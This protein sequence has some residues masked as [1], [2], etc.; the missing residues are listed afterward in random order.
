MNKD[1]SELRTQQEHLI[2]DISTLINRF[3]QRTECAV[4]GVTIKNK[5]E[6]FGAPE[7]LG[8]DVEIEVDAGDA[9]KNKVAPDHDCEWK[10]RARK[11]GCDVDNGDPDCG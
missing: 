9:V 10:E 2:E 3:Q 4:L 8:V 1:K 5:D 7:L 6:R 11:H